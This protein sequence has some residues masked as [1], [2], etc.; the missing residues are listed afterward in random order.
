MVEQFSMPSII[1]LVL[2]LD[3]SVTHLQLWACKFVQ[4]ATL[5]SAFIVLFSGLLAEGTFQ[6][7]S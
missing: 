6:A 1:C 3:N 4:N 7:P 5:C 2:E